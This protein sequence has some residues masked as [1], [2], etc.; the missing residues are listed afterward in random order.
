M[1]SFT[2]LPIEIRMAVVLAGCILLTVIVSSLIPKDSSSGKSTWLPPRN[3]AAKHQFENYALQYTCVWIAVFAVVILF[4]MYEWFTADHYMMLCV[5]LA[6]PF[7]LQ[8]F[9]FPLEAEKSLPLSLRYSFKA[10][11]W[12]AIFSFVGN[13]WY[14]HYFY[15]VLGAKYTFPAHRLNN[16]PIALFFATHFYFVTYHTFSNLLL[17]KIETTFLP[18]SARTFLFWFTVF[19][20]SY[21]TAFMET[22]TI[23]GFPYYSFNNKYMAYTLG[24]AFYGI[25]FLVSYPVFY[26][27]DEDMSAAANNKPHS[28]FQTVMEAMGS[29]M[30]VLLL[31]DFCRIA[32]GIELNI[33]GIAYYLYKP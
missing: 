23:S 13:Y 8:P 29:S 6:A 15:S 22:L 10:N 11:V 28:L 12:I 25:Y 18:G 4:Q 27:L 3:N 16:V 1:S 32:C 14:T 17:R 24:S 26:R 21:F 31:L 30:I 9:L 33:P 19:G 20:F 5:S 2:D 7:L